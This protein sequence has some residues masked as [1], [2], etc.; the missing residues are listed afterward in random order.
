LR[1]CLANLDFIPTR[2]SG[3][4]V[5]GETLAL[6]LAAAGQEV[7]MVARGAPGAPAQE[8][9]QG[10]EVHRT[11]VSR[12]DWV[13]YAWQAAP[14]IAR[15]AAQRPFDIVHF[16][17]VHFAWRFHGSYIASLH[18]SFLQRLVSDQGRPYHA[19][20]QE[21]VFRS[22]YY[23][24]ARWWAEIPSLRRA[25]HLISVSRNTADAFVVEGHLLPERVTVIPTGINL[26]RLRRRDASALR[27]RLG[28]EGKRVLLYVGFCTPR[29]G[30]V[31]LAQAMAQVAP[32]ARLVIVGR[33]EA[34]YRQEFYQAL[35][36]ERERVIE[37]GYALDEELPVYYS[38]ADLLVFPTLLEGF[39]IPLVEAL[40]C[41]TPVVTTEH[42][43]ASAETAGP[44]ALTVPPHNAA[45][46]AEAINHLL[47]DEALRQRLASDGQDWAR[48][49]Y[50]QH[51]MIADYLAVYERFRQRRV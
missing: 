10:V 19:N 38:L 33:W 30:L 45:A 37:I 17:D 41:G 42:T 12:G 23:R 24:V 18:Q 49:R 43:G 13:A 36:A 22:F 1:I 35:G 25:T 2:S 28:L 40:A 47:R 44:G 4:A 5:F 7:V 26:D 32:E 9:I 50:D 46:L 31:Y 27:Q 34:A 29:K 16:L 14:L 39:G 11:A 6:G 15:L 3:L 51:R 48:Q 20:W 21:L 8:R